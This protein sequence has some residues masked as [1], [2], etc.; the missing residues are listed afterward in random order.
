MDTPAMNLQPLEH[1][2]QKLTKCNKTPTKN[3]QIQLKGYIIGYDDGVYIW[4][5]VI[6]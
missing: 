5:H 6:F 2:I 1:L 3:A 4:H